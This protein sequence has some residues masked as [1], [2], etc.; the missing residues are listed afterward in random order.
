MYSY[1]KPDEFF[2]ETKIDSQSIFE[3]RV[4]HV[5]LDTIQLPNG[6]TSTREYCKHKGAVCIVPMTTDEK[7]I[8]VRQ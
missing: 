2:R 1:K 6:K 8:C 5:C 3:G 7:V 4:L